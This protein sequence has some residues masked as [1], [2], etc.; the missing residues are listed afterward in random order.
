MYMKYSIAI[1][2]PDPSSHAVGMI[3]AILDPT[4]FLLTWPVMAF[5]LG[6]RL[7][8]WIVG[9][10]TLCMLLRFLLPGFIPTLGEA[11][12]IIGVGI[13]LWGIG[14]SGAWLAERLHID[15]RLSKWRYWWII[16][17]PCIFLLVYT[18][19]AGHS[20]ALRTIK[21]KAGSHASLSARTDFPNVV[22]PVIMKHSYYGPPLIYTLDPTGRIIIMIGE[23]F[24]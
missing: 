7:W 23:Y 3:F 16:A 17:V 8:L 10:G 14:M 5:L 12:D 4:V 21:V 19:T 22:F 11:L 2:Y 15:Q 1:I 13:V 24:D 6:R 20:A 9:V 18:N